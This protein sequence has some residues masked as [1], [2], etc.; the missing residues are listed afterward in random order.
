[1]KQMRLYEMKSKSINNP[2]S[3]IDMMMKIYNYKL[4]FNEEGVR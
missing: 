3:A 4:N 1:M 2:D